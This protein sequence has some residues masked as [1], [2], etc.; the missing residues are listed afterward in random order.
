M[1]AADPSTYIS[2]LYVERDCLEYAYAREIIDRSGLPATI[3]DTGDTPALAGF[4]PQNLTE[5]K[6]H[7]FLAKNRGRFFKPCPGTREYQCCGYHVLNIG[8]NCPM[9]CVYCILQA[10]LNHPW[11]SF[12]VNIE[13][14]FAELDQAL[15][16]EP[17]KIFR[18]GT[19]EFTDSLALDRLSCLSP[20][21]VRYV[22]RTNN[23]YL[24]LKTKSA[25]VDNL[26]GLDHRNRTI[27]SWSL[28]S[29]A[30]ALREEIRT[31]GLADRLAAAGRCS[32]WGYTLGFHF[33]PVIWHQDWEAGYRST[34][35]QLFQ[36]VDPEKIAWISLGALRFL[37]SLKP[38]AT[39][40]FPGSRFFYEEFV[41]GLDNKSRYFRPRRVEMYKVIV[42]ELLKYASG[43]TC[44][45]FCM[46][47]DAIWR[48]VFGFTPEE[49][50]GLTSMLDHA[51]LWKQYE[52]TGQEK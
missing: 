7:L 16:A 10:Y 48:E 43:R 35:R 34:I 49:R 31:A 39:A 11:L 23:A 13:D 15:A 44:I 9:D 33:D 25:M 21:I 37:P 26:E 40:R 28:N 19:G 41:E 47:S 12:F 30:V 24:E 42:E 17:N 46:E 36:T 2:A 1:P 20:H 32:D 18:I 50:G 52:S 51:V 4:S 27:V 5:G 29:P 22:S 45:Y 14:M 6:R 3:I 8:M 38:I